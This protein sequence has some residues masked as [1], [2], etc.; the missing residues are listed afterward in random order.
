M[1]PYFSFLKIQRTPALSRQ[2]RSR[3]LSEED[4]FRRGVTGGACPMVSFVGSLFFF[5]VNSRKLVQNWL[6]CIRPGKPSCHLLLPL[7][8]EFGER[9]PVEGRG[10]I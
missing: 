10:R 1:F 9:V 4:L 3:S 5:A 7:L 6:A 8:S 2:F